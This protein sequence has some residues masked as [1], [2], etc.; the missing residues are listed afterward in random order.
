MA[1]AALIGSGLE[2]ENRENLRLRVEG[3]TKT[4]SK[5]NENLNGHFKT[6]NYPNERATKEINAREKVIQDLDEV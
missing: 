4:Y 1:V 6:R 2:A 5:L 3:L